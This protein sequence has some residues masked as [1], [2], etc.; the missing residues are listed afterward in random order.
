[1][2]P[3]YT[4]TDVTHPV[5]GWGGAN[6]GL[7]HLGRI[8]NCS[9]VPDTS[10]LWYF[11]QFFFFF[12]PASTRHQRFF[13]WVHQPSPGISPLATWKNAR[14]LSGGRSGY[15]LGFIRGPLGISLGIYPVGAREIAWD[16]SGGR[17]GDPQAYSV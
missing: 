5:L 13:P 6:V 14:D 12:S 16:F 10:F 2:R 7:Q 15:R 17:L 1:M 8:P 4:Q 3:G 11:V 9:E